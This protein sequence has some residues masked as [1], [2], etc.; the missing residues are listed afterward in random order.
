MSKKLGIFLEI[1]W[2]FLG[3]QK[4]WDFLGFFWD[5]ARLL[6]YSDI[7]YVSLRR[8]WILLLRALVTHTYN[9]YERLFRHGDVY[10]C[11]FLLPCDCFRP[12]CV[13]PKPSQND[14]NFFGMIPIFLGFTPKNPKKLGCFGMVWD[15][16]GFDPSD[17]KSIPK[18]PKISQEF[19]DDPKYLGRSARVP[20]T[21][22]DCHVTVRY[23]NSKSATLNHK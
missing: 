16:L 1:F 9:T 7:F 8:F 21:I 12:S 13:S 19:W 4:I 15:G 18:Y 14:P 6:E 20:I 22:N 11:F 5:C 17:P 23:I 10:K 3:S 2:N